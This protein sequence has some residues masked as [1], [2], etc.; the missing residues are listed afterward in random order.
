MNVDLVVDLGKAQMMSFKSSLPS[1]FHATLSKKAV[2][3]LVTKKSVKVGGK[4]VYNL[5]LIYSEVLGLQQSKDKFDK[6]FL[7]MN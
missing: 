1:G 7:G 2:T 6:K 3:R 4:E 5:H